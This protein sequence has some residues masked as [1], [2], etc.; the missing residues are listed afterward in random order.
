MV[1]DPLPPNNRIQAEFQLSV[2]S[3]ISFKIMRIQAIALG[4]LITIIYS[5]PLM[6]QTNTTE[7]NIE[8]WQINSDTKWNFSSDDESASI[9]DE[10]NQL[11]EYNSSQPNME[12][13]VEL[14]QENHK[15]GNQGD[16]EDYSLETDVYN[17]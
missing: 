5:L 9:K 1:N 6:A 11:R 7:A 16:V 4:A 2:M 10:L 17:Y 3:S 12:R 13:D 15:W 8:D 14:L